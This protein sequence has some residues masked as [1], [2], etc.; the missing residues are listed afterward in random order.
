MKSQKNTGRVKRKDRAR[1]RH[2]R[3]SN[4]LHCQEQTTIQKALTLCD[5]NDIPG[6]VK[7]V[8]QWDTAHSTSALRFQVFEYACQTDRIDLCQALLTQ[9]NGGE[10]FGPALR[11]AC[12]YGHDALLPS[13]ASQMN[14]F[15]E[16][17]SE[18]YEAFRLACLFGQDKVVAYL[19]GLESWTENWD[20][21]HY[22]SA[23]VLCR[24]ISTVDLIYKQLCLLNGTKPPHFQLNIRAIVWRYI[25]LGMAVPF[26]AFLEAGQGPFGDL[27]F[28]FT[29]AMMERPDF[30]L[31]IL[32]CIFAAVDHALATSV[33]CD[34]LRYDLLYKPVHDDVIRKLLVTKQL[35]AVVSCCI[36]Q[37][38]ADHAPSFFFVRH[39]ANPHPSI[40]F[41]MNCGAPP[42]FVTEV[43]KHNTDQVKK[44]QAYRRR[45]C[46]M[47]ENP[48]C[49]WVHVN[50]VR[51]LISQYVCYPCCQD[52]PCLYCKL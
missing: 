4:V 22:F 49:K 8:N 43:L 28:N 25:P 16:F 11:V 2:V 34:I 50:V 19:F 14:L 26:M 42:T 30:S 17:G 7:L 47:M 32:Q 39:Y 45:G 13:L 41:A 3:I 35:I 27:W 44:L 12:Q 23:I 21:H 38:P 36:D 52:L 1:R 37:V 48:L 40:H 33:A 29:R 46:V 6:T 24:H 5:Q 31:D 10:F 20:F 51:H 15:E 9:A 18:L